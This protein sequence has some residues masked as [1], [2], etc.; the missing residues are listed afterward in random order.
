MPDRAISTVIFDIDGVVAAT[1]H[2][3]AWREALTGFADPARFTHRVYQ[4]HVAG[5]PRM[6]GARAALRE[7]GVPDADRAAVGYAEKKQALIDELIAARQFD[8]FPDATRLLQAVRAHGLRTAAA[9]SSKNANPM[10][11]LIAFNPAACSMR[12]TPMYAAATSRTASRRRTSSLPPPTNWAW[13]LPM[14]WWSKNSPSGV[15][16]PARGA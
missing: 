9:S 1:P 13:R 11:A 8:V 16:R 4:Q 6:D 15:T 3:Q 10:L 5:K 7:L 14:R 12:S 2:E